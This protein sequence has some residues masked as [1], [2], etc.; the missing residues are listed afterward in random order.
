MESELCDKNN[1]PKHDHE[2]SGKKDPL[3]EGCKTPK[4][5]AQRDKPVIEGNQT[6]AILLKLTMLQGMHPIKFSGKPKRLPNL[7]KQ[8]FCCGA[9]KMSGYPTTVVKQRGEGAA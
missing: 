6:S 7:Q 2:Q 1:K 3:G 9:K 4:N 5:E 8:T